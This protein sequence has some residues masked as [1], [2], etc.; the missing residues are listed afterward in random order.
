MPPR[1]FAISQRIS[2]PIRG[3][4]IFIERPCV[5]PVLHERG[6]ALFSEAVARQSARQRTKPHP[7]P[8]RRAV[9]APPR[10][11]IH[12][13]GREGDGGR[14]TSQRM[15]LDP[16]GCSLL[17][18]PRSPDRP[19]RVMDRPRRSAEPPRRSTEPRRRPTEPPRRSLERPRRSTKPSRRST[20]TRRRSLERPRRSL[21]TRHRSTKVSQRMPA[22][23]RC[24][25]KTYS[26]K[27][28]FRIRGTGR[29]PLVPLPHPSPPAIPAG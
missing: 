19:R 17:G 8:L 11:T 16:L 6:P 3:R 25:C 10:A 2:C 22:I 26:R 4:C 13:D 14:R 9:P 12:P 1:T 28:D 27:C 7:P 15:P 20:E 23:K 5:L 24:E 21:E 18:S 29:P